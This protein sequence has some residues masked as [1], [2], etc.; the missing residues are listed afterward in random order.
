MDEARFTVQGS[1]SLEERY[2]DD[3]ADS[4][5]WYAVQTRSRHEKVFRDQLAQKAIE[6]FLPTTKRWSQWKD[7]RKE[8]ELPLFAGYCFAR[9]S[10]RDRIRVL[11]SSGAVR[12]VGPNGHPESVPESE[13]HSMRLL[14]KNG[15]PYISHPYA[16]QGSRVEV[17]RGP[18]QG[19]RGSLLRQ[20]RPWRLVL[21][22]SLIQKSVAVEIDAS[23]VA[24][25]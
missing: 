19:A 17:I 2:W 1:V 8:I 16:K 20:A 25:V 23:D 12:I 14:M 5:V 18:L 21:S 24:L 10:L 3:R 7:R 13:I 15:L 11:Q 22:I 4:M 9:F 6:H